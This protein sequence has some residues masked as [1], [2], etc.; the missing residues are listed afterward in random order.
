MW[1]L[2]GPPWRR[3]LSC[4]Y[5]ILPWAE[6]VRPVAGAQC[7]RSVVAGGACRVRAGA[8]VFRCGCPGLCGPSRGAVPAVSAPAARWPAPVVEAVRSDAE[9]EAEAESVSAAGSVAPDGAS[10][11]MCA[12]GV[13]RPGAVRG[14]CGRLRPGRQVCRGVRGV[15][16]G[17]VRDAAGAGR[18]AGRGCAHARAPAHA[19]ACAWSCVHAHGHACACARVMPPPGPWSVPV[20]GPGPRPDRVRPGVRACG[21]AW[22][23]VRARTHAHARAFG[24]CPRL[25]LCSVWRVC[26]GPRGVPVPG[27]PSGPMPGPGSLPESHARACAR[28]CPPRVHGTVP[29]PVPGFAVRVRVRVCARVRVPVRACACAGAGRGA[30]VVG[31]RGCG[32]PW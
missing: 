18:C 32:G 7:V 29:V 8:A 19:R 30:G 14:C 27:F 3:S 10:P 28:F 1:S 16:Q 24:V 6:L 13:E 9:A 25:C 20:L 21:D 2:S 5:G 31:V 17:V 12:G 15:R 26:P 23:C 11:D 4:L 22:A